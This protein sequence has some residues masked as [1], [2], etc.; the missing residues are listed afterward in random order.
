MHTTVDGLREHA[1]AVMA[2]LEKAGARFGDRVGNATT[3]LLKLLDSCV[4]PE[5]LEGGGGAA[6][7]GGGQVQ[8]LSLAEQSRA[9]GRGEG[10][11]PEW[12]CPDP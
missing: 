5:D 2:V 1:M 9:S 12:L 4:L 7:G 6:A 3:I 11:N 10:P 8:P